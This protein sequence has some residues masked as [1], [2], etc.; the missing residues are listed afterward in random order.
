MVLSRG[1]EI[2]TLGLLDYNKYMPLGE[3]PWCNFSKTKRLS[4]RGNLVQK[5]FSGEAKGLKK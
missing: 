1:L 3:L 4:T 5:I 2:D